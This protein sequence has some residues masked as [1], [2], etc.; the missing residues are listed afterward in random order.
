MPA[1]AFVALAKR[2]EL[3]VAVPANFESFWSERCEPSIENSSMWR[4]LLNAR[5]CPIIFA[6]RDAS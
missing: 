2:Q 1:G 6:R 5:S 4:I 3:P